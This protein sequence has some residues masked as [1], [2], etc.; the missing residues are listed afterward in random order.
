MFRSIWFQ[1]AVADIIKKFA[2]K[3][4]MSFNMA[5]NT[6]I[7]K[8]QEGTKDEKTRNNRGI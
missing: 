5:V 3:H 2:Q 1:R 6:I 4:N 7:L 8:V